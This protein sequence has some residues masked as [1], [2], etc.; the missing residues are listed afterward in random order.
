MWVDPVT[1]LDVCDS[2]NGA[3]FYLELEPQER[4]R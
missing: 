1:A 3:G 4:R 2:L